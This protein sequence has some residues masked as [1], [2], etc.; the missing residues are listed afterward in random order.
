MRCERDTLTCPHFPMH[1]A[2][3]PTQLSNADTIRGYL[4]KICVRIHMNTSPALCVQTTSHALHARPQTPGDSQS[5]SSVQRTRLATD[6]NVLSSIAGILHDPC[7]CKGL[8]GGTG[9]GRMQGEGAMHERPPT[10]FEVAIMICSTCSTREDCAR[11]LLA[12][13]RGCPRA[14]CPRAVPQGCT[15]FTSLQS[16]QVC[17]CGR[18]VGC[19]FNA[20]GCLTHHRSTAWMAFNICA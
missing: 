1:C 5:L 7:K 20:H 9:H 11:L 8:E 2:D 12:V 3:S 13:C 18:A 4:H 19:T 15:F 17:L 14:L 16:L 10:L 6:E